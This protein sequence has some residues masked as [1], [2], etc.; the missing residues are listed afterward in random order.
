[1]FREEGTYRKRAERWIALVDVNSFYASCERLFRPDLKGRPVV[2]LSNNDGCVIARSAEAKA[3][4]IPMGALYH[5]WKADFRRLGVSVFSSNYPLYGD[6][7]D[8]VNDLYRLFTPSVET[9]SIDESFLDLG[10]L[11]FT[12]AGPRALGAE[13]RGKVARDVGLPVCVGLGP[14]KTLAKIAN[15]VA[16]TTPALNGVAVLRAAEDCEQTRVILDRMSLQEVWG[17]SFGLNKKLEGL[18]LWSALD[19]AQA[20]PRMIRSRLGVVMERMVRELNGLPCLQLEQIAPPRKGIRVSRGFGKRITELEPLQAAV[21]N[22][23]TRA[24]E[25]LRADRRAASVLSVYLRTSPHE[26]L[27]QYRRAASVGFPE[28]TSDTARL[29]QAAQHCLSQLYK[30]GLRYQKTGVFLHELVDQSAIQHNLLSPENTLVRSETLRNREGL[31]LVLDQIN[32]RFGQDTLRY[33]SSTFNDAWR[34]RRALVSHACTTRW[35][36]LIEVD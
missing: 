1:M 27:D 24:G 33:G 8:R 12:G 13:I 15:R 4:D 26:G 31:M 16:K 11:P 30:P 2:V 7:S 6:L 35:D 36:E 28:A 34:M 32:N 5:E 29:I 19:L 18:G 14:T 17:I 9:Y 10:Q 20:D 22:F 25:K 3:L 21:A 23:A